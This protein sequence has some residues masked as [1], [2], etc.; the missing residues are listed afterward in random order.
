MTS[1][2]VRPERPGDEKAI[3]RLI[4]EAFAGHPHSDGSEPA[5]VERLRTD[6]DLALSL[7]A[8]DKGAIVGQAAIS[9]VAISDG[10]PGWHG[11]GPVSVLPTRQG[12]GIG[13]HLIREALE[14]MRRQRAR[15]L[16]ALR[17]SLRSRA[18]VSGTAA[19]VFPAPDVGRPRPLRRSAL[20]GRVPVALSKCRRGSRRARH[21]RRRPGSP[22]A[23]TAPRSASPRP[24][25]GRRRPSPRRNN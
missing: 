6:G 21:R 13:S 7:V 24:A 2:T 22:L 1:W 5:I 15:L 11:L 18:E 4:E 14:R 10:S 3:Q 17:L 25:A 9:P 12:E 23:R 16:R 19:R 8:D 20:R